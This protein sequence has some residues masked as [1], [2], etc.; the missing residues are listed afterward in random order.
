MKFVTP[1]KNRRRGGREEEEEEEEEEDDLDKINSIISFSPVAQKGV[2]FSP[3]RKQVP[4]EGEGR[5][6]YYVL[7]KAGLIF[8]FFFFFF[9]FFYQKK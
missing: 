7:E 9:F 5:C 2:M 3:P 6:M 1:K 8:F 4:F